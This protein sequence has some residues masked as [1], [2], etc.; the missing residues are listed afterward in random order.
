VISNPKFVGLE[1]DFLL[2][3]RENLEPIGL[4]PITLVKNVGP[5]IFANQT[6]YQRTLS[7]FNNLHVRDL[8]I[9]I[10]LAV[11]EILQQ[12]LFEFNDASTRLEI[13]TI[14][15]NYLDVVRNGGGILDY[16]VIMDETNNT[17]AIIDQNFGI[18]DIGVE[19]A[20]GLQ[21]FINRITVLKTGGISSGGFAAV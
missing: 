16:S 9:T 12:Y 18:I 14:V 6:A 10:E 4:N 3:D 1:Y 13:K 15:D 11:I 8:L 19:P 17:P 21:K 7:S 2:S 20:L 5:M